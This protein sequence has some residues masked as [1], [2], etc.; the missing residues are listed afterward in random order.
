MS[1]DESEA[2]RVKLQWKQL[3]AKRLVDKRRA[4]GIASE[5]YSELFIDKGTVIHATRNCKPI[6]LGEILKQHKLP[7]PSN[8][9]VC[10][11]EGGYGVFIKK[12]FQPKKNQAKQSDYDSPNNPK[13]NKQ[14]KKKGNG[15]L[16]KIN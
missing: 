7:V 2:E 6:S 12:N 3:W 15:W 10:P 13:K 11:E 9:Q 5:S 4:E 14:L 16:H 1:I 8:L